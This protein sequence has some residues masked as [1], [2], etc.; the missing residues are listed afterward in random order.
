MKGVK[1]IDGRS[2][3]ISAKKQTAKKGGDDLSG[4]ASIEGMDGLFKI[5]EDVIRVNPSVCVTDKEESILD[6]ASRITSGGRSVDY[7]HPYDDF[8]RIA[9]MW[10][11]IIG[12]TV[13]IDKVALCMIA[14]EISREC[15][16]HK[17]DNL[18]D[19]AGYAACAEKV[20]LKIKDINNGI[21]K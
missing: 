12:H 19:I 14:V 15:N 13:H 1:I 8:K 21:L 11:A 6:E 18:V 17:R 20:L 10:S 9:T 2:P 4:V 3:Q 5:R 16:S 7:G